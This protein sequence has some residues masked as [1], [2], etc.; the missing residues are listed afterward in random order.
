M[1]ALK[2]ILKDLLPPVVL[3]AIKSFE[4]YG[5]FG[6]YSSWEDAYRE[7]TGYDAETILEKVKNSLLEVKSG[8]AVYARDG[9]IFDQLYYPFPLLATFLKIAVENDNQLNI[10]DFGG[11]LGTSYFQCKDFLSSLKYLKWNIVEQAN[12]VTCG[13]Q[14]FEDHTLKF[15]YDIS[16]CLRSENPDVILLSGV[17]Q[18]LE[19]PYTFL[20]EL[21]RYNFT[22]IIIDRTPFIKTGKDRLT[23]QKVPPEI[24]PASYPSWFFDLEKFF[25]FFSVKYDLMF[26]F[27]ALDR[28]N[29]PSQYKGFY[30]RK[31]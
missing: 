20:E 31:K 26:E 4:R 23:I 30:F 25:S 29:I 17:I 13:K 10:L 6:D 12:F 24:Y 7:S 28:A 11:S 16:T 18:Y 15:F 22:H 3:K 5:Y 27:D 21:I 2:P 14:C 1:N 19:N 8:K 9:M